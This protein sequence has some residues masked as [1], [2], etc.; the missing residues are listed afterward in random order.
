M[1]RLSRLSPCPSCISLHL[2]V[3][4]KVLCRVGIKNFSKNKVGAINGQPPIIMK[5]LHFA[6]SFLHLFLRLLISP[7][8]ILLLSTAQFPFIGQQVF[9]CFQFFFFVFYIL[10]LLVQF[11]HVS[12]KD[13]YLL[14][15]LFLGFF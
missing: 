13:F 10:L 9:L 5:F 4:G 2:F 14:L 12:G 15:I 8:C 11:V 7:P 1:R 3:R 6:F